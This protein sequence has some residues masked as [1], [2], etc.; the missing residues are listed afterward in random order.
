MIQADEK[1]FRCQSAAFS[2]AC[3]MIAQKLCLQAVQNVSDARR[4]AGNSK[5]EFR[6]S[7][8]LRSAQVSLFQQ[9]A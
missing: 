1:G 3:L 5:F 9:R 2:T 7:K 4:G 8:L 6:N